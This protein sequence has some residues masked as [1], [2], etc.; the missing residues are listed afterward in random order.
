[1]IKENI[2]EYFEDAILSN[3]DKVSLQDYGSGGITFGELAGQIERMHNLFREQGLKKGDKIAL[4]GKNSANWGT[5]YIATISYCAVIVPLLQDFKPKDV[6]NLVN[7]SESKLLFISEFLCEKVDFM[8]FET[9][10]TA[11]YLDDYNVAHDFSMDF[12]ALNKNLTVS[13]KENF[14]LEHIP[15]DQLAAILYTSGTSGQ[16]K[17]VMLNHNSLAANVRYARAN[18]PLESGDRIV[19]FLPLA[20]CYGAAFEFLFPF[21][22]GC[23]IIFLGKLPSPQI[24]LRA[25]SEIKPRLILSV[26]L[27]IEK[28][29]KNK[30]KPTIDKPTVKVLLK[31]PL[32]NKLIYNKVHKSLKE[33]FGGDFK[34]VVVGGAKMNREVET[35]LRKIGFNFSVGYGM[36]E[37]GP[38]IAY[39]GYS[40]TKIYST[41]KS[42]DTLE[43]KIDSKE[44]GKVGEILVKGENVM[45]GYYKNQEE[46]DKALNKDGWLHTGDLGIID[47]DGYIF[48]KGRSKSMILTG[49]GQNVYPEEIESKFNNFPLVSEIVV[50][51]RENKITALIYP[52]QERVKKH[53]LSEEQITKVFTNYQK[54]VNED[55]PAYMQ[56][57]KIII[58]ENEFEKTPKKSI[59]RYLYT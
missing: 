25:F 53:S 2:I 57:N 10:Q 20:H 23:T 34:E 1:M 37:C 32:V 48:I 40:T 22:L 49:S 8:Q 21:S 35:F 31:I 19:S 45:L 17:G 16:P 5:I 51:S 54:R 9:L 52:D 12:I 11:Y 4:I 36:T 3:W 28:I 15:N 18:M 44:K 26:P 55:L 43:V 41:G 46:T 6:Y 14:K 38:L 30:I 56:V 42:V 13:D 24:I 47:D 50:I 7:H 27:V 39:D 33:A 59:K 29:Y 58:Q